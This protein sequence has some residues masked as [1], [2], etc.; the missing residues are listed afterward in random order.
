MFLNSYGANKDITSDFIAARDG[1]TIRYGRNRNESSDTIQLLS[2]ETQP[3]SPLDWVFRTAHD[4]KANLNQCKTKI[5]K[6][7]K[8]Q[9]KCL[10]PDF[11][12]TNESLQGVNELTQQINSSLQAINQSINSLQIES[13]NPDIVKIMSNI[14][15]GL[16][17]ATKQFTID[18][19]LAQEGF[20]T[21]YYRG[22]RFKK[23]ETQN[24]ISFDVIYTDDAAA[25]QRAM[26]MQQRQSN[27]EL[28]EL[29]RRAREVQQLFSDL[30]TIIV[31]QGTVIDR[32]DYNISEALTNT[33][34]GHEEVV[35]AEKYQKGSK[36]WVCAIIMGVLVFILFI[37]ALFK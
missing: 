12:D 2:H 8:L 23:N 32:I 9:Q 20:T 30:A 18:F 6:L 31:E 34:K 27:N 7:I 15:T 1:S 11:G 24:L 25:N 28:E 36:M 13:T 33:Q 17:D 29:T 5:E 35:E 21:S 19:K 10:M 16:Y 22:D 3:Q 37:M 4:I 14:R 26:E